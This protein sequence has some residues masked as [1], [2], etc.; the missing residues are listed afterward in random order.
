MKKILILLCVFCL[1]G[2]SASNGDLK[3]RLESR[4]AQLAH[5]PIQDLADNIK[6][7]YRY[8]IEPGIGRRQS[9]QTSN[10][11]VMNDQE[12]VMNLDIASV[13]NT[14]FYDQ[15][16]YNQSADPDAWIGLEGT[17][18]DYNDLVFN[19]TL[20][21]FSLE[22]GQYF[23]DL[24][25]AYVNFYAVTEYAGII[26]LVTEMMKIGKTVDV[27]S[28]KVIAT[29]SSKQSTE[30]VKEKLD[31]F[32]VVIPESGRIEE[33]MG[34]T[35]EEEIPEGEQE[36]ITGDEEELGEDENSHEFQ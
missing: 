25:M 34:L 22:D 3:S 28:E 26:N 1:C 12:F 5:A 9:T 36:P 8:Y 35:P 16:L 27:S 15:V 2:C 14:R 31:L 4:L 29:Y 30:Y 33:L 19:Y 32:E 23:I 17:Y 10:V 21:I 6:P 7:L 24:S 18:L 13:I 20:S 11:F